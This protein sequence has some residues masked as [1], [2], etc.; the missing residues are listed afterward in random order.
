MMLG[1]LRK[2][3]IMGIYTEFTFFKKKKKVIIIK[4]L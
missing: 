3:R 1:K 4:L 2:Y